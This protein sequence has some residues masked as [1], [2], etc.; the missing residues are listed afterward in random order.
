MAVIT[1]RQLLD[2][3]VHFGHQTRRW[4]P[5]VKRFILTERSGIHVIDLQQSLAYI[6]KA[7][8]FVK[9]VRAEVC[10]GRFVPV[11][12][13][14]YR[15]IGAP[16]RSRDT[17]SPSVSSSVSVSLPVSVSPSVSVVSSVPV[18]SFGSVSSDEL[19]PAVPTTPVAPTARSQ[20]RR[21]RFN[22]RRCI[23]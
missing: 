2:S 9:D 17:S 18:S 12:A 5:K 8:D 4:N 20:S 10:K 11:F 22:I 3:G 23:V 21:V 19:Q 16:E 6:D 13:A 7:Y 15:N 1:I 14:S